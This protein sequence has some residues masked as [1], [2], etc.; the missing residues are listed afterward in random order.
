MKENR[1]TLQVQPFGCDSF[2]SPVVPPLLIQA[3]TSCSSGLNPQQR[4]DSELDN[5]RVVEFLKKHLWV[6][7][8]LNTNKVLV[9]LFF[10]SSQW[11]YI[12]IKSY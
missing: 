8:P 11:N 7:F 10:H 4:G 12:A 5:M 9:C 2:E 3:Q 1:K 6:C